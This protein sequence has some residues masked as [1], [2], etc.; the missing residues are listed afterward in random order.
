MICRENRPLSVDEL[1]EEA[2]KELPAIGLTTI[3]RNVNALVSD[4]ELVAVDFP[5]QPIRY[6]KR[7]GAS[8][9]HFICEQCNSLFDLGGDMPDVSYSLP[10]GFSR[11]SM[12]VVFYGKCGNCNS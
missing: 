5:G 10:K 1:L 4:N 2:K 11:G 7:K 9:P 6:E 3:Y 12:D 8:S